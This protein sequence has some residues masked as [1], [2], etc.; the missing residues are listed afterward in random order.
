MSLFLSHL[1]LRGRG[2]EGLVQRPLLQC[3]LPGD[4]DKPKPSSHQPRLNEARPALSYRIT[5]VTLGQLRCLPW[6]WEMV[7]AVLSEATSLSRLSRLSVV[8]IVTCLR[9]RV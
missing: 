6:D 1:G 7:L 9:L 5:S 8:L 3:L 4:A 2:Q